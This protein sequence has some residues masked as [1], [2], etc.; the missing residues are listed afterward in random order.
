MDVSTTLCPER[1]APNRRLPAS[2]CLSCDSCSNEAQESG[3]S[4]ALLSIR[5]LDSAP[6]SQVTLGKLLPILGLSLPINRSM[7]STR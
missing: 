3:R 6:D 5:G 1:R 2:L 7:G 4:R